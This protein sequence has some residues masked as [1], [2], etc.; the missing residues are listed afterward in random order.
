M[1]KREKNEKWVHEKWKKKQNECKNKNKKCTKICT[2]QKWT[3]TKLKTSWYE[4]K[5]SPKI[6][7]IQTKN[8]KGKCC[9]KKLAFAE[10]ERTHL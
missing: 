10:N 5:A 1:L 4:I 6:K 2:K 7:A 9:L 3:Y 8:E